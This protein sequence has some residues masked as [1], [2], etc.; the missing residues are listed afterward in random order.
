[1]ALKVKSAADI[2]KKWG[3]VTPGRSS[4]YQA[5]VQAA[6]GDW[7]AQTIANAPNY[8][9]AVTAA[10]IDRRYAGGVRRAGPDKYV[11]KSAGVGA[12]RYGP[13]VA[14]AVQDMQDGM[15][16]YVDTLSGLTLPS[17][18]PRGDAGNLA[19]VAAIDDAL[20]KRRIAIKTA[21]G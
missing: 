10:D 17:R 7:Q 2:A 12:D 21:G 18:K 9:A 6:G 5:G 3:D 19:R 13:G 20:H 11:R 1:M 14:A 15:A 4:F 16:P 8:K